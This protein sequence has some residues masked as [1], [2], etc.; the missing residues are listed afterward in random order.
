[1]NRLLCAAP[2]ALALSA[3][4]CSTSSPTSTRMPSS[5]TSIA[6]IR[7]TH[8]QPADTTCVRSASVYVALFN[9]PAAIVAAGASSSQLEQFRHE[10]DDL[11]ASI[12]NELLADYDVVATAYR[13]AADELE[14]VGQTGGADVASIVAAL[15]AP[16][17]IASRAKLQ[18]RFDTCLDPLAPK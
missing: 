16:P 12:P 14:T 8:D 11:R 6:V 7:Q 10:L 13:H 1:M 9:E 4:A 18:T 17:V 3:V 2:L 15:Q 5:S